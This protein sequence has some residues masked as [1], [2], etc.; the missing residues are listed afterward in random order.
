MRRMFKHG[1]RVR[2]GFSGEPHAPVN[3]ADSMENAGSWTVSGSRGDGSPEELQ[4][5]VKLGVW[6]IAQYSTANVPFPAFVSTDIHFHTIC[7]VYRSVWPTRE[8]KPRFGVPLLYILHIF[9]THIY[10]YNPMQNGWDAHKK[11][12]INCAFSLIFNATALNPIDS[13]SLYSMLS[14]LDYPIDFVT[15]TTLKWGGG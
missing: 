3:M 7:H 15:A 9:V 11:L 1:T 8:A 14:M 13:P 4:G 2:L 12:A 6:N 5:F 10:I